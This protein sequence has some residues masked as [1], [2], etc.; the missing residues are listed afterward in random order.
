MKN[1]YSIVLAIFFTIA[2]VALAIYADS[3]MYGINLFQ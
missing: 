2:I 1:K 3:I